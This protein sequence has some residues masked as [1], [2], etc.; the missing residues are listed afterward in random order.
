MDIGQGDAVLVRNGAQTLLIDTG[1]R[2]SELLRALA[3][4]RVSRIDA[5][6]LTHL[7]ADHCGALAALYANIPVGDIYV[8]Q[9]LLRARG[10]EET[11]TQAAAIL[12][13]PPSEL[14]YGDR[15]A[16]GRGFELRAL[17]PHTPVSEGSNAESI[18]LG[19]RYDDDEDGRAEGSML[20]TGD[21]EAPELA[22][23][24]HRSEEQDYQVLKVGHHGSRGAVSAEQLGLMGTEVALISVGADNRYGHPTEELLATLEAGEVT[25]F[26][27]DLNGDLT[28][29]F[30]GSGVRVVC[31]TMR[32]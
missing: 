26:R 32:R 27:T 18:C 1:E 15:I 21:A 23:F 2:G 28:V 5:V 19:L 13:R 10:R 29:L 3:R 16:L 17:W 8:A 4:N 22:G 20:L 24:L 7:D 31:A 9:G 6:I 30:E 14:A 25:T 11:L 12:G